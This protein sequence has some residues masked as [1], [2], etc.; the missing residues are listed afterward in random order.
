M[1]DI[2]EP[3]G[4]R[5]KEAIVD[6]CYVTSAAKYQ[7]LLSTCIHES[8]SQPIF[9]PYVTCTYICTVCSYNELVP[10]YHSISDNIS[11]F[12]YTFLHTVTLTDCDSLAGR[13]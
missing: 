6:I 13:Q 5:L 1:Q 11:F 7:D 9:V 10:Y 12:R 2:E 8:L 4:K 3:P